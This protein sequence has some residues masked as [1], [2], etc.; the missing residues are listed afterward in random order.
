MSALHK[1]I[2]L[3]LS[4]DEAESVSLGLSDL[5]CW[6]SGFEA[7]RAG[8]DLAH[9]TP[10]GVWAARDINIKIKSALDRAEKEAVK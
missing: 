4:G 6:L 10:M 3:T 9:T 7:A 1:G 5:L 8:T 2:T